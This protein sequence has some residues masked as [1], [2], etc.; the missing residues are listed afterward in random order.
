MVRISFGCYNDRHDVDRAVHGLEQIVAGDS[1]PTTEPISTARFIPPATWN[2]CCSPST[3]DD[4]P[5]GE[6]GAPAGSR[7]SPPRVPGRCRT[8]CWTTRSC[9]CSSSSESAPVSAASASRGSRSVRRRRC[10]S[11]SPSARIDDAVGRGRRARTAPPARPRVVHVHGRVGVGPDVRRRHAT[12]WRARGGC[13]R[14]ADRVAGRV[15][16]IGG[17]GARPLG[18][19]SGRAVRRQHDE[20]TF[21]AGRGRGRDRRRSGRRLLARIPRRDRV[22]DRDPHVAARPQVAV[23]DAARTP[24]TVGL[25]R[26]A[27]QLDR[28]RDDAR[29]AGDRRVARP[30]PRPRVQPCRARRR[31]VDRDDE[32]PPRTG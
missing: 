15:V 6:P 27:D 13:H 16:C 8:S 5:S 10:S 7:S 22:D 4:P 17:M 20:H 32:P 11:A 14:G 2:R 24:A 18:R 3:H 21:A 9:S 30:V 31:G 23:S 28:Q 26:A 12:W 1:R 25:G 19:R 29:S